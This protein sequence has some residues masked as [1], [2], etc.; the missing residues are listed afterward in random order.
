M[1]K[2]EIGYLREQ[3]VYL[4]DLASRDETGVLRD[5]LVEL[6]TQCEQLAS[7]VEKRPFAVDLDDP[8]P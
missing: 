6:A 4:R 8:Q 3:A 1:R 5:R 2:T 7:D